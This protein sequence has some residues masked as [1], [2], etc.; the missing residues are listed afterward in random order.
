MDTKHLL[1]LNVH[2][3]NNPCI[4]GSSRFSGTLHSII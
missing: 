4:D 1:H 3:K 2:G